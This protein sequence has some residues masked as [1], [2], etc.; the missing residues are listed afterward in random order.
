MTLLIPNVLCITFKTF[1]TFM[2]TAARITKYIKQ[3]LPVKILSWLAYLFNPIIELIVIFC[4]SFTCT[5]LSIP[6]YSWKLLWHPNGWSIFEMLQDLEGSKRLIRYDKRENH[7]CWQERARPVPHWARYKRRSCLRFHWSRPDTGV[8][9]KIQRYDS[10][11]CMFSFY[12]IHPTSINK[13]DGNSSSGDGVTADTNAS[14]NTT[15]SHWTSSFLSGVKLLW[16]GCPKRPTN[17][18]ISSFLIFIMAIGILTVLIGITWS[19]I[20]ATNQR[21]IPAPSEGDIFSSHKGD[22]NCS[23]SKG[24]TTIGSPY[25]FKGEAAMCLPCSSKGE[26]TTC[27]H[28]LHGFTTSFADVDTEQLNTQIHF[29]TDSVFFV[30]DNSTTGHICNDIQ[31]FIPG[32]LH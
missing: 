6:I 5:I 17:G 1:I 12:Q 11:L 10:R 14:T 31:R 30:C 9:S 26:A 24:D 3:D 18:T 21:P 15:S 2:N 29:N 19:N 27:S 7:Y 23:V 8:S 20:L 28:S 4:H 22:V 32:S 16:R 13:T 25:S